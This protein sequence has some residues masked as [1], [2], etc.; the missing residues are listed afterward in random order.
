MSGQ[1]EV[2]PQNGCRCGKQS[3]DISIDEPSSAAIQFH[4]VQMARENRIEVRGKVAGDELNSSPENDQGRAE[5]LQRLRGSLSVIWHDKQ[6][7]NAPLANFAFA[8]IETKCACG[9]R[10]HHG[11]NLL[12]REAAGFAR[13][14]EFA[15]HVTLT[16]KR[17]ICS[18]ADAQIGAQ[19]VGPHSLGQ[20][21][22]I[23]AGAP[24]QRD[25]ASQQ[26]LKRLAIDSYAM[27]E[28]SARA[29]NPSAL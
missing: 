4:L 2:R 13:H 28:N 7:G 17:G 11:I 10:G 9:A 15:G 16:G 8:P 21:E 29:Q 23:G 5:L 24:D 25:P 1:L 20:R 14:C 22:Q 12:G 3:G 26:N 19:H 6:I 27:N 18:Q